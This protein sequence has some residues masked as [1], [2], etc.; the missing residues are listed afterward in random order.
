MSNDTEHLFKRLLAICILSLMKYH[1]R[2]FADFL[3]GLFVFFIV[4]F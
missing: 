2:S 4:E 1:L 3:I